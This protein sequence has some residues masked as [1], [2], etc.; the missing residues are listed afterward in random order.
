MTINNSTYI[1]IIAIMLN[2]ISCKEP[3]VELAIVVNDTIPVKVIAISQ[4]MIQVAIEVSG[5]FTTEDETLLSFKTGGIIQHVYVKEGDAIKKGQILASMNMTEIQAQVQQAKI[6]LEKAMRDNKRA[7]NLYKDSVATLEQFQNSKT[8][9]EFAQQQYKTAKFNE[10]FSEI[11]ANKNG[12]VLRKFVNDG[13]VIAPGSP[14]F[15]VNGAGNNLWVLKVSL[16]VRDWNIIK[17]GDTAEINMESSSFT[18]KV[19]GKSE[20][21]DPVTGTMWATIKP[22]EQTKMNIAAGSFGKATIIPSTS[23]KAWA[24]PYDA[25]LDG[26][27]GNGYVFIP[28]KNMTAEKVK[29]KIGNIVNGNVLVT[30]GLTGINSIIVLGNAYLNENTPIKIIK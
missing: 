15:Q 30:E 3:K 23:F 12:Y 17:K 16:S 27:A 6:G 5:Q 20:S 28:K 21:A 1:V 9:L 25:I 18:G 8:A 26:N 10:N 4:E 14:V 19:V 22:T 24:I 11:K 29:I 13:Q 2:I 7:E